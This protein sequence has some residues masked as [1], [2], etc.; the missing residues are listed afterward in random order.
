MKPRILVTLLAL[1]VPCLGLLELGGYFHFAKSAPSPE[2]WQAARPLVEGEYRPGD[3]VVIAP[4]WA[5]PIARWKFGNELMPLR[6]V[7]RPDLSRYA[8]AI[9][10]SALG[11]RSPELSGWPIEKEERIGKVVVRRLA[12]P[13]QPTITFDFTDNLGP[14]FAQ[15]EYTK[16]GTTTLC[17]WNSRSAIDTRGYYSPAPFPKE[18]FQCKGDGPAHFVGVTVIQDDRALPRRC[19]FS[20][21]PSQ[22]GETVTRYKKV[23][24]GK[25]IRGHLGIQWIMER[26][27]IGSPISLRVVVNGDELGTVVH[28]DGDGWKPFELPLGDHADTSDATVEFRV[29]APDNKDRHLCFEADSR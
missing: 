9:E 24:L 14:A 3:V 4:R 5:E 22:G 26:D 17:G 25:V 6:E 18:R 20:P 12:N 19:I 27:R 1:A 16:Q 29:T 8:R 10:V 23:P 15:V 7:A 28:E 11:E 21:P 13:A 2:E